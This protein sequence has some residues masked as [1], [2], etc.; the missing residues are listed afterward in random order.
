MGVWEMKKKKVVSFITMATLLFSALIMPSQKV[1][2]SSSIL[3]K[4]QQQ[5]ICE[6]IQVQL[7]ESY[8]DSY[9]F[10]N[11]TYDI[12]D[13]KILDG[14]RLVDINVYVDMT[15]T[16]SASE[17]AYV[18]GMIAKINELEGIEKVF[19][20]NEVKHLIMDIEEAYNNPRNVQVLYTAKLED[21]KIKNAQGFEL[22]SR[23]DF[24]DE[25][26]SLLTSVDSIKRSKMKDTE[27]AF[28][29]GL[30]AF[31]DMITQISLINMPR[32]SVQYDRIVARDWA[33]DNRSATPEYSKANGYGSDCANFV[34]RAI[35]KGG[36]PQDI[37]G[38]WAHHSNGSTIEAYKYINWFRTGVNNNGGV[39]PYMVSKG[40]FYEESSW[41]KAFAGS[42]IYNTN[43]GDSHVGLVTAGDGV[44]VYYADHSDV[45][46]SGRETLLQTSGDPSFKTFKFYLPSSSILK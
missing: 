5:N 3:N 11:F 15:L 20:E 38:K 37:S 13:E 41:K 29:N 25:G 39:A 17:N 19:A 22:F 6:A 45:K 9:I 46:K 43:P 1:Q 16:K 31:D 24:G 8:G 32:A 4:Y 30:K 14:E 34:S 21:S 12:K 7:I 40:Y 33:R 44:N 35:N 36:I 10:E 2:A 23:I 27:N 42:I 18:Q 26:E 28:N